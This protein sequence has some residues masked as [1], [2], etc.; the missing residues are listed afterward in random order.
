MSPTARGALATA[1]AALVLSAAACTDESGSQGADGPSPED[2]LADAKALIDDAPSVDFTI[3]TDSLPS[4]VSGLLSAEGT[5]TTAPAFDGVAKVVS[6]VTL[7]AEVISVDGTVYAKVGF[8]PT[9][10][11]IDPASIGA[12]DPAIFFD[13]EAGVSSL[14]VAT[15]DVEEGEAERDGEQLLTT[16]TGTLQ[17]ELLK[18]ML[19][20]ADEAGTF[21]VTYRLTE[22][23][24]LTGIEVTGPFYAG[25]DDVTYDLT[26]DP[27]DESVEI[28]A[29]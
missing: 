21:D 26:V 2:R 14:L 5:G 20:T 19:P 18:A 8:V 13:T 10:A 9:F 6:G 28:T 17:G 29:P 16:I 3:S 23:D 7:D 15:D 24:V 25:S 27:S 11:E 4:G 22:E 12:P 1:V